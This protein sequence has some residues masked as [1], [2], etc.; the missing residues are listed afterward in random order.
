MPFLQEAHKVVLCAI[1]KPAGA[2]LDDAALM[3][4]RHGV[5]VQPEQV[6]GSDSDAGEIL[7]ARAGTHG[8]DLL[9]M[10]AYGHTRWRELVFGGATRDV[11]RRAVL[12]VLFAS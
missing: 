3:L 4:Q 1:G 12:P 10:G 8:A 7:M 11:L 9:V 6:A 2:G 5:Q